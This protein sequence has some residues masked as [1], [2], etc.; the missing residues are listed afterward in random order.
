MTNHTLPLVVKIVCKFNDD[1][2]LMLTTTRECVVS[3]IM[4]VH[5][6]LLWC[7]QNQKVAVLGSEH[8]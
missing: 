2:T 8:K 7:V 3:N 4:V 6:D 5:V 1:N